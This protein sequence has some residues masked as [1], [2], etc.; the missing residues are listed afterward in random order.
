[1]FYLEIC[2]INEWLK[3]CCKHT[4]SKRIGN[5]LKAL[6]RIMRFSS[7]RGKSGFTL[8]SILPNSDSTKALLYPIRKGYFSKE[9]LDI[10]TLL[11]WCNLI[12]D[13]NKENQFDV[14]SCQ[15]FQPVFT[16][17]GMCH[18]FNP[19]PALN[20]LKPSYFKVALIYFRTL[21]K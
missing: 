9:Q 4:W 11:P 20:M 10:Y 8:N 12:N 16:D 1:M 19:A 15:L 3:P 14:A 18:S 17:L 6:M 13:E 7:R 2:Q 21:R 5:N